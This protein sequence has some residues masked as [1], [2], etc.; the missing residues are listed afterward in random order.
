MGTNCIG[1]TNGCP[2][3]DG[4]IEQSRQIVAWVLTIPQEVYMVPGD[5]S[6]FF[7]PHV[8]QG[9]VTESLYNS[10]GFDVLHDRYVL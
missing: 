4:D 8:V 1:C 9:K 3:L 10:A 7:F 2:R 5:K 6:L